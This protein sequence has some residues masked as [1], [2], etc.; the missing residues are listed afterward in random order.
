MSCV[1][2]VK[3]CKQIVKLTCAQHYWMAFHLLKYFWE[4]NRLG[5]KE[6]RKIC[7]YF[8]TTVIFRCG[9]I[10]INSRTRSISWKPVTSAWT[11]STPP[12][13]PWL[14]TPWEHKSLVMADLLPRPN[15]SNNSSSPSETLQRSAQTHPVFYQSSKIPQRFWHLDRWWWWK[16]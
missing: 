12:S 11:P 9:E 13:F 15:C 5:K 4:K 8:V 1:F 14:A 6:E 3:K 7:D 16:H 2:V 10:N